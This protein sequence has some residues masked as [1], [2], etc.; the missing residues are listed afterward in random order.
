L[1][2]KTMKHTIT[3][4]GA[5]TLI[6]GVNPAVYVSPSPRLGL[7]MGQASLRHPILQIHDNRTKSL[8]HFSSPNWSQAVFPQ[9]WT[10]DLSQQGGA[11]LESGE[12]LRAIETYNQ[13]L[14]LNANDASAY[15]GRGRA[16]FA[17]GDK[18]GA[19]SDFTQALRINPSDASVYRLR[20]GVYL[21]LG[22]KKEARLDF[23]RARNPSSGSGSG[24]TPQQRQNPPSPLQ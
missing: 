21:T 11:K 10:K 20:G 5:A 18:Q 14:Q 24:A 4:L 8:P 1:K 13:A 23:E 17:L 9:D 12:Y 15:V 16:R 7:E 3:I 22:K 19:I 2:N 6:A